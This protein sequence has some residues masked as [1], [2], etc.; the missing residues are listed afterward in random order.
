VA[1][2]VEQRL[3]GTLDRIQSDLSRMQR[4]QQALFAF[5]DTLAKALL[6]PNGQAASAA[7]HSSNIVQFRFRTR[8][9]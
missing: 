2:T 6:R 8:L 1:T 5:V 4:A 3:A 7:F 9:S